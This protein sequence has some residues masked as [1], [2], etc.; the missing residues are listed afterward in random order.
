MCTLRGCLVDPALHALRRAFD[1]TMKDKDFLDEVEKLKLTANT[2]PAILTASVA[3]AAVLYRPEPAY[4]AR[5]WRAAVFGA[6]SGL[7]PDRRELREVVL[8]AQTA[9]ER[10]QA[11]G[12]WR[13]YGLR[14]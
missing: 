5:L 8:S 7:D 9:A 10:R 3:A 12:A 2:Q 11:M 1:A 13:L 14:R 4:G 6:Y